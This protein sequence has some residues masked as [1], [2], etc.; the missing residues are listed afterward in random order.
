MQFYILFLLSF[1]SVKDKLYK[2]RIELEEKLQT[3]LEES[4]SYQRNLT[5]AQRQ[6]T[7]NQEKAENLQEI[8]NRLQ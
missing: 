5:S 7:F 6:L 3:I 4:F 2:K 8:L 1:S